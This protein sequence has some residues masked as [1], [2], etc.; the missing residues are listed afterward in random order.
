MYAFPFMHRFECSCLCFV[1]IAVVDVG[2]FKEIDGRGI[3]DD[4]LREE[5]RVMAAIVGEEL[6]INFQGELCC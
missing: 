3:V 5:N 2:L 1:V 4:E 6:G